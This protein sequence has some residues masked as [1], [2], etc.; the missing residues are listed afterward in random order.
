MNEISG[1]PA[2]A[3]IPPTCRPLGRWQVTHSPARYSPKALSAAW[4][5]VAYLYDPESPVNK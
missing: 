2:M 4:A 5:G 1:M 3:G